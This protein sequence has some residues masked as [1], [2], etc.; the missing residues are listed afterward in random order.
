M[1]LNPNGFKTTTQNSTTPKFTDLKTRRPQNSTT[2][3]FDNH[4]NLRTLKLDDPNTQRPKNLTTPKLPN[5]KG[6]GR[7]SSD[8]FLLSDSSIYWYVAIQIRGLSLESIESY[9]I[10][11]NS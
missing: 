11:N 3:K 10:K 2:S 9:S 7:A 5:K 4:Q 1:T 6:Q 8:F